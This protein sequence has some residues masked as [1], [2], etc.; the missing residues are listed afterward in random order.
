MAGVT[1][2]IVAQRVSSLRHADL[3][4]VLEEGRVIGR[5]N[6]Q[7]LLQTCPVYREIAETQMGTEGGEPAWK[8]DPAS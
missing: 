7:S 1:Q 4:L 2:V 6:H 3:I 8:T 5:G